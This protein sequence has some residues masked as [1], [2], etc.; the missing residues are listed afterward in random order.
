MFPDSGN[1]IFIE[2]LLRLNFNSESSGLPD[3][4]NVKLDVI[5]FGRKLHF[6]NWETSHINALYL[7][8]LL[9]FISYLSIF[10]RLCEGVEV[11]F[12]FV[13]SSYQ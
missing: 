6:G 7:I 9:H 4:Y 5:G 11:D 3:F 8:C 2:F 13:T 10:Q 12:D 1:A